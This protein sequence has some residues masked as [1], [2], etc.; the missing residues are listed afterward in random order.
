MVAASTGAEECIQEP[1]RVTGWQCVL[2]PQQEV[3]VPVGHYLVQL[4]PAASIC[5]FGCD[6]D[7]QCCKL[8]LNHRQHSDKTRA[9]RIGYNLQAQGNSTLLADT[10]CIFHPSC[11]IQKFL[12]SAL[13]TM[14]W[15]H[16]FLVVWSIF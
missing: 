2:S 9:L 14:E 1:L 11:F 7:S 12:S 15:L 6:C 16:I 8:L 4:S 3:I 5:S 13:V 10:L